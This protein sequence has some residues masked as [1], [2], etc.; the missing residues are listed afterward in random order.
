MKQFIWILIIAIEIFGLTS[1]GKKSLIRSMFYYTQLSNLAALLS[2][3]CMLVFGDQPWVTG[4]RYLSVCM[5]MMT[6]LVTVFV[7]VPTIKD[8][9]LLLWS[10]VGFSLHIAGPFANLLSYLLLETHAQSWMIV[11]PP[12]LTLIYGLIMLWGNYKRV[13][14]GPYPFLR[15]YNQS[16]LATVLWVCALIILIGAIASGVYLIG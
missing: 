9:H 5:L 1:V 8:T 6:F 12:V 2:L 4:F 7:L 11:I 16:A 13:I 10:R 14:D 3:I 15:V